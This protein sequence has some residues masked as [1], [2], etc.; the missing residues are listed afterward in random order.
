ME[1][2]SPE[3]M[4]ETSQDKF[5]E[6]VHRALFDQSGVLMHTLQDVIKKIV[7]EIVAQRNQLGGQIEELHQYGHGEEYQYNDDLADRIAKMIEEQFGIKPK[8]HTFV[9]RLPYPEWFDRVPLPH[10]YK[11]LDFSKFSGQDDMST[12]EHQLILSTMWR[13]IG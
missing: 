7:P 8:E 1:G 9:Y 6:T 10:R 2:Q 13:G 3:P 5:N 11:V 4:V 12:M